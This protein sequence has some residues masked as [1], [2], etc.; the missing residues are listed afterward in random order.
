MVKEVRGAFNST[1]NEERRGYSPGAYSSPSNG[2]ARE[3]GGHI[4][5]HLGRGGFGPASQKRVDNSL[6]VGAHQEPTDPRDPIPPRN[7]SRRR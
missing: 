6:V 4:A 2:K 7:D 1:G 5:R 3:D